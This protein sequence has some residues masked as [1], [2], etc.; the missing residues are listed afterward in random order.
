MLRL[1]CSI[2]HT[3]CRTTNPQRI[4]RWSSSISHRERRR[5]IMQKSV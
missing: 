2:F 1:H 4:E 3:T 5:Q